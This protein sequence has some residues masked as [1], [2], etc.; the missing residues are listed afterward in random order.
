MSV[1]REV[2]SLGAKRTISKTIS[3]MTVT[4]IGLL[5]AMSSNIATAQDPIAANDYWRPADSG[6]YDPFFD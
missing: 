1:N 2:C 3:V 6:N 4:A 5:S